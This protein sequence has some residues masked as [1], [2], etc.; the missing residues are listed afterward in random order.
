MTANLEPRTPARVYR[1]GEGVFRLSNRT[2]W[3]ELHRRLGRFNILE[4]RQPQAR[5]PVRRSR[6]IEGFEGFEGSGFFLLYLWSVEGVRGSCQCGCGQWLV[7][8]GRNECTRVTR[9][10]RGDIA[11]QFT[12][13]RTRSLGG[14]NWVG[15]YS[16]SESDGVGDV[17]LV[18]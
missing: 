12:S 1:N 13:R 5:C 10:V 7:L 6:S 16:G 11:G 8:E 17:I 2:H 15:G 4:S 18:T 14:A 9:G 3:Q